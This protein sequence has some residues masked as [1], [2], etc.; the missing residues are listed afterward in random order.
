MQNGSQTEL[1]SF[2]LLGGEN[3]GVWQAFLII[4]PPSLYYNTSWAGVVL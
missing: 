3:Q 4:S 2:L 1:N